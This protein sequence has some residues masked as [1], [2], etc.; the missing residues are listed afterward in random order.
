M[1]ESFF[2]L[3]GLVSKPTFEPP[4]LKVLEIHA[5]PQ[6]AKFSEPVIAAKAAI[7]IDIDSGKVLFEK[8]SAKRL[9]IASLTKLMTA[10]VARENYELD[11]FVIVSQN[12]SQQPAAKIW[13]QI[14]EKLLVKDLL[15]AVL[16]ESANDAATALA[17]KMGMEKFVERMNSK[18]QVLGLRDSSFAN[19]VGYDDETNF[20]TVADLATLAKYFLRDDF[21]RETAATGKTGIA[22]TSGIVHE[23]YSTNNLF[24]SYLEIRGLKTGLTEEAGECLAAISRIENG[25]EILAIILNSPKRFQEGKALLTWAAKSF[26][27]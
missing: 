22:S 13:L 24:G 19:P 7:I 25:K 10:V 1:L 18:A 15:K 6:L 3:L 17:E 21:L 16:I 12:A 4:P 27:W 8:N 5:S 11:D 14:G 20:S 9:P 26:R 23:L 2:T